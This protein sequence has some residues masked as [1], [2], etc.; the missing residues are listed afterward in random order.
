MGASFQCFVH[1]VDD[2]VDMAYSAVSRYRA[3]LM[4]MCGLREE[5]DQYHQMA[6]RYDPD[7]EKAFES[8]MKTVVQKF[9]ETDEDKYLG[10]CYFVDHSDC[11]GEFSA[12][13]CEYIA[14][15]FDAL[16]ETDIIWDEDD[17]TKIIDLAELFEATAEQN[18]IMRIF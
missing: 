13:Q 2:D 5:Y 15:A 7:V 9:H 8:L 14:K 16:L 11:D 6:S 3:Y 18:G 10:V 1:G 17:R 12:E 4:E